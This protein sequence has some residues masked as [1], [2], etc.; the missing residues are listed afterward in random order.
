[1]NK[2]EEQRK[3]L[4]E[5]R[6]EIAQIE[7]ELGSISE[8]WD[9]SSAG[10]YGMYHATS[11]LILGMAGAI[12]SL[13]FNIIGSLVVRQP[14]LKIIQVYLTFPLGEQALSSDFGS[15]IALA[16]GCCLYIGTGMLLGVL[17]QMAFARFTPNTTLVSR[18]LLGTVLGLVVWGVNFYLVLNSLQP[19]LFGGNWIVELVPPWVG[20]AT[21]LVFAWTMA[22]LYPWGKF[23]PYRRPSKQEADIEQEPELI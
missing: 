21:H 18:L 7:K 6:E 1:M 11:G 9:S 22:W 19:A 14:P 13:L 10:Y 16:I 17:F 5:L 12:A 2:Q 4:A 8:S 15:G 3:R 20:A 23:Q